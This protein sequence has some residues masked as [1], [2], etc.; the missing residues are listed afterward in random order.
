MCTW[1]PPLISSLVFGINESIS[2]HPTMVVRGVLI[3][4]TENK[5]QIRQN[6]LHKMAVPWETVARKIV[7]DIFACF[8]FSSARA[9]NSSKVVN[10]KFSLTSRN[11]LLRRKFVILAT[12]LRMARKQVMM[13]TQ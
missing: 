13:L 3:S 9:A 6:C 2:I 7:L 5:R 4:K 10:A 1:S 11:V 12:L 8:S